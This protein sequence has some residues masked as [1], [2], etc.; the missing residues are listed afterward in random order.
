GPVT[1]VVVER[2]GSRV[3]GD[4]D[5]GAAIL[6]VIAPHHAETIELVGIDAGLFGHVGEGSVPVVVKEDVAASGQASRP[7][8]SRDAAIGAVGRAARL[9]EMVDVNVEVVGHVKVEMA[10]VVVIAKRASQAP[11]VTAHAR[12]AGDAREGPVPVVV[13]Q[14]V[15]AS[16][17]DLESVL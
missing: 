7:A 12:L 15:P 13:V 9:A 16:V 1:V 11:A 5:V 14:N 6:V 10:V 2:A 17:G 8:E 3:V 4:V